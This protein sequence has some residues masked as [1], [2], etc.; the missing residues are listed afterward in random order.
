MAVTVESMNLRPLN[1]ERFRGLFNEVDRNRDGQIS[2]NELKVFLNNANNA[3][4]PRNV[5]RHIFNKADGNGDGIIDYNEFCEMM[6]DPHQDVL[7][8]IYNGAFSYATLVVPKARVCRMQSVGPTNRLSNLPSNRLSTTVSATDIE[9][10]SLGRTEIDGVYEDE[11]S[12]LPPPLGLFVL[13]SVI[14]ILFFIDV[15]LGYDSTT[16][17]GPTAQA[18]IYDPRHREEAWRFVTYMFVHIGKFHLIVNI[19]VQIMLGI[20]LE[21][22][23]GWW[24]VLIVY[25]CGVAFGSLAT[26][27]FDPCV[28]LAGASGGVYSLITAHIGAIIMNWHEM[29]FPLVQLLVFMLIIGVDVGTAVYNRYTLELRDNIGYTAHLA[30]ALAGLCMGIVV[31][32][33]LEVQWHERVIK[34]LAAVLLLVVAIVAIVWNIANHDYYLCMI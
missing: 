3:R 32:R 4:V 13:T 26:S 23:H 6:T 33:N 29:T 18:L 25:M 14:I 22:I 16:A 1:Q 30:G 20:P 5:R 24:R 34:G 11:Y 17:R 2:Y 15:G 10:P 9:G 7:H 28:K 27:L 8:R 12:C 21:M 19:L 31:L